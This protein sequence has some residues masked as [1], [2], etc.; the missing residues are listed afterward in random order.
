[1]GKWPADNQRDLIAFYGNPGTGAVASQLV[2]VKPPFQMYYEGKPIASISFHRKAAGA[3]LA[4]LNEIW[5]VSGQNQALLNKLGVSSFSGTYNPRKVRGSRTKWS[6]HAFGAA[7]DIDAEHNGFGTG[8]GRMPQFVIDAFK[9]QGARW[10]GDYH[11]RTDPMHFEFCCDG[12]AHAGMAD[13]G[14]DAAP[15]GD[16]APEVGN[17]PNAGLPEYNPI[18]GG[19]MPAVE[20]GPVDAHVGEPAPAKSVVKS[21]LSWILGIL[22]VSNGAQLLGDGNYTQ[23]LMNLLQ[24]PRFLG[25][26]LTVGLVGAGIYFYWKDHG[27]GSEQ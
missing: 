3:L 27:K 21:K 10:G 17:D 23:I 2:R 22:G 15:Q 24:S 1:M 6:N 8:H 7:I 4:A 18:A 26:L 14:D 12:P 13:L 9:R 25:L 11:G 19:L 20:P 5:R 16:E